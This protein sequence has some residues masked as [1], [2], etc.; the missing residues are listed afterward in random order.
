MSIIKSKKAKFF[1]FIVILFIIPIVWFLSTIPTDDIKKLNDSFV[2]VS[3]DKNKKSVY[4]IVDKKP[5]N[6]VSLKQI[7]NSAVQAIV[8]SEDWAFYQHKGF[9]QNQ[10]KEAA[11][12]L[13]EGRRKR[14]ASTIGQQLAKNLFLSHEKT[15]Y[16]KFKEL[17]ISV[18]MEEK[19]SKDKILETYLNVIEFAPGVYGIKQASKY[20]F[21]KRPDQ[22]TAKEGA[23]LAM[24]LPNPKKNGHSF[25]KKELTPF[26]KKTI[27]NILDK[28]GQAKVL[29]V[30]DVERAKMS[31]LGWKPAVTKA[32]GKE[33]LRP[34]ELYDA[35]SNKNH[36][37][38][39]KRTGK[40]RNKRVN[41]FDKQVNEDMMLEENPEFDDDAL[42]EDL[43]GE[44]VNEFTRE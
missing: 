21:H 20:Y 8:I 43:N 27:N 19:L 29:K 33:K 12:D 17:L 28:M 30:E 5:D 41:K 2:H 15:F 35:F 4:K 44:G 16:R 9:D 14:G 3:V 11:Q 38:G 13:V 6:W 31:E 25:R 39:R 10:I 26:A 7:N 23:F 42:N 24:L 40:K 37:L 1:T 34:S 18:H 22:L 32:K 36:S